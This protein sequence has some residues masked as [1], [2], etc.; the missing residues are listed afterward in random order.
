MA[1]S[2]TAVASWP[3]SRIKRKPSLRGASLIRRSRP[4]GQ[5]RTAA[6]LLLHRGMKSIQD[7]S[8][9]NASQA[10]DSRTK[11]GAPA[12]GAKGA[13]RPASRA[14]I[15]P[16]AQGTGAKTIC[17]DLLYGVARSESARRGG[18]ALRP[19]GEFVFPRL[20]YPSGVWYKSNEETV[21][22][23]WRRPHSMPMKTELENEPPQGRMVFLRWS[24]I[25]LRG[26]RTGAQPG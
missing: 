9:S 17:L 2:E 5:K 19:R 24:S 18:N 11:N 6:P 21:A 14:R 7:Y 16:P 15:F 26:Q 13:Q 4:A 8:S 12:M 23:R 1:N 22:I 10:I 20:P 3:I 25:T